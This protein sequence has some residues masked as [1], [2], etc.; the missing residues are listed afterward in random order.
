[1][2]AVVERPKVGDAAYRWGAGLMFVA[3]AAIAAALAFQYIGGYQ[4]CPLCLEQRTAYYVGIPAAFLAL[5]LL[6][7]GKP[8]IAAFVLFAVALAFLYN[9]GL[10]VYH[11]GAE[12]K[13]WD[14]PQT[15]SAGGALAP[16]GGKAGGLLGNLDVKVQ[17]CDEAAWRFA[18]LSFA[19]WNVV[20]SLALMLAGLKAAFAAADR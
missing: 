12:W 6:S 13:F 15:C 8:R 3:T 16:L 11:A 17:R 20:I 9:A 2:I 10:G 4:P 18:G 19:G 1:M 7:A 14:G 5:V